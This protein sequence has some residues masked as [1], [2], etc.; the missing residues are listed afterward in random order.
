MFRKSLILV[1]FAC[2]NYFLTILPI[3]PVTLCFFR[4]VV[5]YN[6]W[7]VRTGFCF[8]VF[9]S[10]VVPNLLTSRW[11]QDFGMCAQSLHPA[12]VSQDTQHLLFHQIYAEQIRYKSCY[13]TRLKALSRLTFTLFC[14]A[15]SLY[16]K[17][18]WTSISALYLMH[19]KEIDIDHLFPST[20]L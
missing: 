10:T 14:P 16:A 17:L 18:A 7:S 19:R 13:K 5:V 12:V 11:W 9:T 1:R 2:R 15:S 8:C 4:Y 20:K 6:T 3:C